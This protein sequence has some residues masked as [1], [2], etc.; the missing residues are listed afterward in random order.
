MPAW[1]PG[2]ASIGLLYY[3]DGP[4]RF[5]GA[6]HT[7]DRGAAV[8]GERFRAYKCIPSMPV[9]IIDQPHQDDLVTRVQRHMAGDEIATR[10]AINVYFS[11][12]LALFSRCVHIC[13]IVQ[14]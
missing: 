9:H 6:P 1:P 4:P 7:A 5:Q 2:I 13:F 12:R 14:G 11:R 10:V 3:A 8:V